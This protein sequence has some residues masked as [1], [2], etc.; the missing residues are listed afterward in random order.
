MIEYDLV[1][2]MLLYV[3]SLEM[4]KIRLERDWAKEPATDPNWFSISFCFSFSMI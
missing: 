3:D 1:E 4:L 2:E